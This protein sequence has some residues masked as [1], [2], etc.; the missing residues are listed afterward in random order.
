MNIEDFCKYFYIFTIGFTNK[1]FIQSFAQD[2]VFSFKWGC[3]EF[4]MP[5]TEKDCFFSLFQ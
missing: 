5:T 1:D 4:D 3:L 2:Q